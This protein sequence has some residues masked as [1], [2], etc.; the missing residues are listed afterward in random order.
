MRNDNTKPGRRAFIKSI[1]TVSIAAAAAAAG[2]PE[3]VA[4]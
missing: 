1:G 4:G 2:S 3:A